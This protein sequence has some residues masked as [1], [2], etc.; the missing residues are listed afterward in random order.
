MIEFDRH[1]KRPSSRRQ[2]QLETARGPAFCGSRFIVVDQLRSAHDRPAPSARPRC[3]SDRVGTPRGE[4]GVGGLACRFINS[5][6]QTRLRALRAHLLCAARSDDRFLQLALR[7]NASARAAEAAGGNSTA[8]FK[9]AMPAAWRALRQTCSARHAADPSAKRR[10]E[11]SVRG[12]F[13]TC[14]L[15]RAARGDAAGSAFCLRA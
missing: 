11:L 7:A 2:R 9:S 12:P 3:G 13:E 1:R 10:A 4:N 5:A 8:Q 14:E 6:I 15:L